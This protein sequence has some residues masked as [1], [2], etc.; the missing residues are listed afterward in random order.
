MIKRR[1]DLW[2]GKATQLPSGNDPSNPDAEDCPTEETR[3]STVFF[4]QTDLFRLVTPGLPD[5]SPHLKPQGT[6]SQS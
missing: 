4:Y 5:D 3:G 1:E 2:D 6:H